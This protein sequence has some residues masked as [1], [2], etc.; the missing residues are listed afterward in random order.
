M[1]GREKAEDG[2]TDGG[3]DCLKKVDEFSPLSF[4]FF[5]LSLTHSLIQNFIISTAGLC[6]TCS[7]RLKISV[8]LI[9]LAWLA[10]TMLPCLQGYPRP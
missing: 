5:A 10:P 6:Y 7:I 9:F 8:I 1:K 2:A 3:G 4:I